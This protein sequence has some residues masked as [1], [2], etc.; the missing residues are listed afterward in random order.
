MDINTCLICQNIFLN[1]IK[2]IKCGHK[3]CSNCLN[4]YSTSQKQLN[5]PLCGKPFVKAD[6]LSEQNLKQE[7]LDMMVKC[8]CCKMI[9]LS[10]Y[11]SHSKNCEVIKYK[12][13]NVD[14]NKNIII[15]PPQGGKNR[16][17][18]N[19]TLCS[20]KN[21]YSVG[22]IKHISNKH[23]NEKGVC[24][25][26]KSL[27]WGNPNYITNIHE[28]INI[29]HRLDYDIVVDFSDEI[30]GK[31]MAIFNDTFNSIIFNFKEDKLYEFEKNFLINFLKSDLNLG[32][33]FEKKIG[34]YF[35]FLIDYPREKISF[36]VSGKNPNKL[37][38]LSAY[39]DF[40][41]CLLDYL[42][43]KYIALNDSTGEKYAQSRILTFEELKKYQSDLLLELNKITELID[44]IKAKDLVILNTST[45]ENMVN[46]IFSN[47]LFLESDI[48]RRAQKVK[49]QIN[50]DKKEISKIKYDFLDSSGKVVFSTKIEKKRSGVQFGGIIFVESKKDIEKQFFKTHQNGSKYTYISGTILYSRSISLAK[51]VNIREIFL[52]KIFEKL[53]IGPEVKFVVNPFVSHDLYIVA[54]D[55]NNTK[56]NEIFTIAANIYKKEEIEELIKDKDIILEF[57]KFDLINRIFGIEDLHPGNYGI[58]SKGDKII[59]FIAP[60]KSILLTE[61]ILSAFLKANG[62]Y[63]EPDLAKKILSNREA[64][65]KFKEG[66]EALNSI[67]FENFKEIL[68]SAKKEIIEFINQK[69][70]V[71]NLEIKQ[72]IGLNYDAI[73]NLNEYI[74]TIQNYFM[75]AKNYFEKNSL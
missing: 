71:S 26:C 57:T 24:A 19:C 37:N 55:L 51:P 65:Q 10:Q 30:P 21:F 35:Q 11:S 5:C 72:Q 36:H 50:D 33:L 54:K 28:H 68:I 2:L 12:F 66:L 7:I 39:I 22:Y 23:I 73:D 13:Q 59:D 53:G 69:D 49:I 17:T 48:M 41:A 32:Q 42:E 58:L 46:F 63:K 16:Q 27:P 8:E 52:Y 14:K 61:T 45:N 3:M 56:A 34:S 74:D 62:L 15:T 4:N 20:E 43:D 60:Q 18:F 64:G 38:M 1:P 40:A 47:R 44:D 67:G 70:E 25:I 31:T 75:L 29:R 6:I 9:P